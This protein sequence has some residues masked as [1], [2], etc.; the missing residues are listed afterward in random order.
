MKYVYLT[1][2]ISFSSLV[3][4][5]D[6]VQLD[7]PGAT[8]TMVLGVNLSGAVSGTFTASNGNRYGFVLNQQGIFRT[9]DVDNASY[10][11]ATAVNRHSGVAG[12]ILI[13]PEILVLLQCS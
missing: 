6:Y 8:S 5:Q 13:I 7:F 4:S 12:I 11:R 1:V 2:L 9:I 10:T 3:N